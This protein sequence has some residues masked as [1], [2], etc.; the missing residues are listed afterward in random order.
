MFDHDREL[1]KIYHPENFDDD[2]C[3]NCWLEWDEHEDSEIDMTGK[4]LREEYKPEP[5]DYDPEQ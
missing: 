4:C 5:P 1:E 2:R 3:P